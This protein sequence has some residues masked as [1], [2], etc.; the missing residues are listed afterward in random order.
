M[1]YDI[2]YSEILSFT[3]SLYVGILIIFFNKIIA[4]FKMFNL[5]NKIIQNLQGNSKS[6]NQFKSNV[7]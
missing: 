7:M 6:W 2:T 4:I 3:T 5:D 1:Y